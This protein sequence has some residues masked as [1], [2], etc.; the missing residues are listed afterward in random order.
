VT[1]ISFLNPMLP[2]SEAIERYL[3][4]SRAQR[5][6]TNFG[7]CWRLLRDRL[8]EAVGRPC[9]PVTNGTLGLMTAVAVLRRR[10]GEDEALMP[11]FA[12][13]PSAQAAAWNG[14]RPV[15]MDVAED[16]WHLDPSALETALEERRGRVATVIALS[17]FGVPPPVGVRLAWE[18]AC[19]REG[20]PLVVDSAAGYG[21]RA[22]DGVPIGGQGDAEI[23][24]FDALKP[25]VAGEGGA[26]FCRDDELAAEVTELI[27]FAMDGQRRVTRM[28]GLNAKMSEPAAAIALA[29]LDELPTALGT[30]R[31][32]A[33]ELLEQL[34][35]G[36][37]R[38]GEAERGSWQFVPV[39]APDAETRDA[40]LEE[41]NRR[42]IEL[43][44][45]YNPLHLM[46][47]FADCA[48]AGELHVTEMLGRRIVNLPMA[49]DL[50]AGQLSEIAEMV[51]AG[52]S[53]TIA[54]L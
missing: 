10:E 28:D 20:V 51:Q 47:A 50:E 40:V 35:E 45:Y 24:S 13:A 26:I 54:Q 11:S 44:I 3:A 22:A 23:V 30:R 21:A 53:R 48:R 34:P 14:L 15:F 18:D 41:A 12:F 4:S 39:T 46:P 29:S 19:R 36:F 27:N 25:L 2:S 6:F 43:R 7:P 42:E 17:A 16:H 5:W 8:S 38:Q 52:R 32:I 1:P 49:L 31:R 33:T 37:R 9:V